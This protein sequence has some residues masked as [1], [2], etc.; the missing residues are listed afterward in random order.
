[1]PNLSAHYEKRFQKA[2]V[3]DVARRAGVAASTVSKYMS[4]K[5]EAC[6]PATAERIV[7]AVEELGYT[8]S[9]NER[10]HRTKE[11]RVIGMAV[12]F[13]R[14][15]D[16]GEPERRPER[17]WSGTALEAEEHDLLLLHYPVSIRRGS[18]HLK[19]LD[20]RVDGLIMVTGLDD[21]RPPK[22]IAAGMPLVVLD[23]NRGLWNGCGGA[24]ADER[25]TSRLAL[26]HLWML[27][28]RRIAHVAA[29]SPAMGQDWI[30][31]AGQWRMECA[32]DW[33]L[34]HGVYDP[35]LI[36]SGGDWAGTGIAGAIDALWSL[37]DPPTALFCSNDDIA[38]KSIALLR[39]RGVET[40][41]DVSV[42][43]VDHM[44]RDSVNQIMLT[45]V[46]IPVEELGRAALRNLIGIMAGKP[47]EEC[48]ECVPVTKLH[49]EVSTAPLAG[50]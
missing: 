45:T 42:V 35:R 47:F 26:D 17:L 2:T 23:Q 50:R 9:A 29:G 19:F 27:G 18:D 21:P 14:T 34:D 38:W 32:R 7:R 25:E 13:A 20:G 28:H 4:G 16:Q 41:R 12:L 49:V 10:S 31:T 6:S 33:M 30:F 1:M 48:R 37:S 43:G 11:T 40:P 8:P 39:Q 3:R 44:R 15:N 5:R 36:V 22:L 46:D 24:F